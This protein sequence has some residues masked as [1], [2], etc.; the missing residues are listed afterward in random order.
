MLGLK[1]NQDP[2]LSKREAAG[3]LGMSPSWVEKWRRRWVIK[4]FGLKEALRSGRKA[5]YSDADSPISSAA[6]LKG[7]Q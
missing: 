1:L 2:Y 5:L 4:G 3:Q 7:V 6:C